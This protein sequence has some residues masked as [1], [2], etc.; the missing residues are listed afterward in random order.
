M[1][2][3]FFSS[4]FLLL[5]FQLLNL[6]IKSQLYYFINPYLIKI[7]HFTFVHI[8]YQKYVG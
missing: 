8:E 7:I 1:Y 5:L 4:F 6:P 2:L 3:M